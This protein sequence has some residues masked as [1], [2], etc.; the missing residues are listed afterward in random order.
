MRKPP[1]T[2]PVWVALEYLG[3]PNVPHVRGSGYQKML[4]PFHPDTKPSAHVSAVGFHCFACDASGDAIKLI[5]REGIDYKTAIAIL[6]ERT[7][8]EDR[9][10]APERQFGESL[11]G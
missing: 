9:G 8:G 3:V 1:K 5:R 10:S 2:Y 7:G 4:C 6:E 11:L